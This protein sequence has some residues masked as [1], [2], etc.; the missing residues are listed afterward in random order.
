MVGVSVSS[1]ISLLSS[2]RNSRVGAAV[3]INGP[4]IYLS[5]PTYDENPLEKIFHIKDI[6][7]IHNE[8]GM[9]ELVD[10]RIVSRKCPNFPRPLLTYK[11][12]NPILFLLG[13]EDK[14]TFQEDLTQIMEQ[15]RRSG[16]KKVFMNLIQGQGHLIEPPYTPMCRECFA[17][18]GT[19][20]CLQ[21]TLTT[22][23]GKLSVHEKSQMEAWNCLLS[24]LNRSLKNPRNE[25]KI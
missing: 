1:Q 3:C 12:D 6:S 7:K 24:F 15:L 21:E 20:V 11:H 9:Q 2:M 8:D 5:D 4:A 23:G 19:D 18:L 22:Y 10:G 17:D 13:S 25:S 16:K 14:Y